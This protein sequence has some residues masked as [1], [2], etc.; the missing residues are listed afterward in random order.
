MPPKR[1]PE[2]H[3]PLTPALFHVLVTLADGDKHGYAILRDVE[4]RTAGEVLLSTGTLYGII[5]RLLADGLI[6]EVRT[7]PAASV[8]DQRR[9]YY[10]LTP[11]G[12]QVALAETARLERAS[13]MARATRG[14]RLGGVKA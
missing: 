9:R 2:T 5:K 4:Q 6:G 11:F 14:L 13:A 7:R 1:D 8:D 10:R 12:R 3:L